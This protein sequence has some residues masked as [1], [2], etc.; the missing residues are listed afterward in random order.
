M[1]KT[2]GYIA[3]F[4]VLVILIGACVPVITKVAKKDA[5]PEMYNERPLSILVLPPI[6]VTTA[7]DAKEFYL[8]TVAEPMSY[9][10]YYVFP[11]E[12]T[13]DILKSV[14]LHDTEIV[15]EEHLQKFKEFFGAD[16]VLFVKIVKWD[17]N[18]SILAG[19]VTVGIEC[20]L[21][22]TTTN[23]DLWQYK[24]TVVINTTAQSSGGHPLVGLIV[25]IIATAITTASTDYVPIA[26]RVNY[27][28]IGSMPY[29]KYHPSFDT[30]REVEIIQGDMRGFK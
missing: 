20:T 23:N 8:T 29:G 19:N 18:Y 1:K 7:A 9:A 4:V 16:A 15:G 30:D 24:G 25:Q 17:T 22:S 26:R 2:A 5:F 12:V 11:I 6:N 14:G 3:I 10:G 27:M 21:K 13:N 28:V